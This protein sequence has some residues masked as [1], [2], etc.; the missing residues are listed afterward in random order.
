MMNFMK[1]DLYQFCEKETTT[2]NIFT[3]P[4]LCR[5]FLDRIINEKKIIS[6][7]R[8]KLKCLRSKLDR[9][10][11]KSELKHEFYI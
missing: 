6:A 7:N 3:L 11:T 4:L 2:M 1:Y 10:R 8:F 5:K 9:I